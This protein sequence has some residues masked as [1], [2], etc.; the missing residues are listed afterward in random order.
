LTKRWTRALGAR[1]RPVLA[2]GSSAE[3]DAVVDIDRDKPNQDIHSG[4]VQTLYICIFCRFLPP[5]FIP[6]ATR[7]SRSR[8]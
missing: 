7:E 1:K 4:P 8:L 6:K 3:M 2:L 5:Q